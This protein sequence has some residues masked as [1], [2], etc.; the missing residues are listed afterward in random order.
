MS[1][2]IEASSELNVDQCTFTWT[3]SDY[4]SIVKVPGYYLWSPQFNFGNDVNKT[5]SLILYP[6][7]YDESCKEFI[8]LFLSRSLCGLSIQTREF[9]TKFNGT[10]NHCGSAKFLRKN[11]Y[12]INNC[13]IIRCQL[14]ITEDTSIYSNFSIDKHEITDKLQLDSL[15]LSEEFSDIKLEIDNEEDIPAHKYILAVA[16]PVFRAMFTHDMLENKNNS[17]QIIDTP[18][19]ILVEMLRYIY[20]GEI[21]TTEPD[22]IL[23]LL[24]VA[25][26]YQINNLKIK[27]GKILCA[28]L[29]KKNAIDFLVASYKYNVKYLKEEVTNYVIADISSFINTE[30]MKNM[31]DSIIFINLIQS[32]IKSK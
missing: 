14:L 22:T 32:M 2:Q 20:T 31:D 16:S 4:S 21:E 26:K 30:E 15:F 12:H 13:M 23:Q 28:N 11:N 19:N 27:C 17:V 24:P 8:S 25:D 6:G 5:F 7:G 10:I 3:I 29:S 18:R 9:C 1:K